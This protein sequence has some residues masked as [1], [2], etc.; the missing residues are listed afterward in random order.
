MKVLQALIPTFLR[1]KKT[2]VTVPKEI[3]KLMRITWAVAQVAESK[4]IER[5]H[6]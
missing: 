5:S 6:Q 1:R 3:E 4:F 2:I